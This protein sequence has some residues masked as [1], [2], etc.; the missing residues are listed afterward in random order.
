MQ[1]D[2]VSCEN[3][4]SV[5]ASYSGNLIFK[6]QSSDWLSWLKLLSLLHSCSSLLS[7]SSQ[8]GH[9]CAKGMEKSTMKKYAAEGWVQ[10]H[11]VHTIWYSSNNLIF[12]LVNIQSSPRLNKW[13]SH[14]ISIRLHYMVFEFLFI[15][16]IIKVSVIITTSMDS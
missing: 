6:S 14:L 1:D 13:V 2:T 3:F 11:Y 10:Q 16:M 12:Q 7:V 9:L 5:P 4:I 15:V 8:K